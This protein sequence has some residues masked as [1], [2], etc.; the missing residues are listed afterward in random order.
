MNTQFYDKV[1]EYKS[2][3]Y[4]QSSVKYQKYEPTDKHKFY[5]VFFDF[6]TVTNKTHKPYLVRFETEDDVRAEFIGDN[7]AKAMLDNLP[8]KSH[9][10]LIAHNANYDCRFLLDY[11]S[12][13]KPLVKGGIILTCNAVF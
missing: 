2:L 7:C 13:Q 11:L 3:E 8:D 4:P 5:K 9:I 6:E 10:M 12:N 1:T